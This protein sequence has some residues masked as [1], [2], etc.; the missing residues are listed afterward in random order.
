MQHYQ[1]ASAGKV[2]ILCR[3]QHSARL[4]ADNLELTHRLIE[5]S[6][7]N[8]TS[9]AE[10]NL[11]SDLLRLRYDLQMTAEELIDRAKLPRLAPRE[12]RATRRAILNCR[13]CLE[14]H[15]VQTVLDAAR[16][17]LGHQPSADSEIELAG[18]CG[19]VNKLRWFQRAD[20]AAIQIM[21][22]HKAKGLEFDLVF[23]ADLYDHV[24]PTRLYPPGTYG[25]VIFQDEIQCLNLHY[26]GITRAIKA[27]V[28]M[29]SSL[30]FNTRGEVKNG[31]PSQ[32]IGR[33][34][35]IAIPLTW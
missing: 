1:V 13:S 26:V 23:H 32:F 16:C 22:L 21:T 33:N 9:A 30:R 5:D 18:V 12:R 15:L 29:T 10:A 27:C 2:A 31:A 7:F 20:D 25:Q 24:I 6:P 8:N 28:L 35:A 34:G 19:D 17:L 3:H 14:S 4:I 11:F